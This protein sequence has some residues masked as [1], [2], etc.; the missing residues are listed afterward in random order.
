MK[1][2]A[3][4]VVTLAFFSST[5]AQEWANSK[6]S[7]Y[8]KGNMNVSTGFSLIHFGGYGLFDYALHDAISVGAELGYNGY[9][10]SSFWRYNYVPVAVRGSFHPFNL[11]VLADKIKIRNKLDPYAGLSMGW[12]IGWATWRVSGVEIGSHHTGGFL[13]RENIGV[14]FYPT[15][16][17]YVN[18]EEG[19]GLGLF[20]FG[21]GFK[22]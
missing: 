10:F 17:F 2:V 22:L 18:F 5:F 12:N 15:Q 11:A 21:V 8:V 4:I 1:R 3:I 14:R 13:F 19:G 16:K 9:S 6:G 20:N 7:C